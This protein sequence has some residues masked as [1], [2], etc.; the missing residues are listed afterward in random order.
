MVYREPADELARRAS[1]VEAPDHLTK[2]DVA[3][4]RGAD[5]VD[6]ADGDAGASP[7][8]DGA[9]GED[10]GPAEGGAP[11]GRIRVVLASDPGRETIATLHGD[12]RGAGANQRI[13]TEVD[14]VTA[15]EIVLVARGGRGGDGGTGGDGGPGARGRKGTDATRYSSGGNGGPGGDGGDGGNGTD[16]AR[17]GDGGEIVVRTTDEDTHLLML[18]A[19]DVRGGKGGKEGVNGAGGA[20]GSGGSGGSSYSWTE[21]ETYRDSNGDS[22]TRTTWH[23]NSGGSAGPDGRDGRYGNAVVADG[24]DG[25]DGSFAI[26]VL[27]KNATVGAGN[28]APVARYPSRYDLRL[29]RFVHTNDNDDGI[30]EP[31]EKVVLSRIAIENVGGMPTPAHHD[32]RIAIR[33][34]G[35]IAPSEKVLRL[36]RSLGAGETHVFDVGL[37]LTL[38]MF[39]PQ[40]SGAPLAAPETIHLFADL[41]D[42]R[43]AFGEFEKELPPDTGRLVVRFPVEVSPLRSLF[44]LG[45]G[46]AARMQWS[47]TNVSEKP[48]GAESMLGRAVAVH[49]VRSGGEL[50]SGDIHLFDP[51][52][53]RVSLEEGFRCEIPRLMPKE[54]ASFET[55]IAISE[56]APPYASARLV[57]AGE[58]GHIA[59]PK[60]IR[61]VQYQELTLRVGRPFDARDADVLF[62]VNNRTTG[63]ELASWEQLAKSNGLTSAVWD[64]ALEGG[65]SVLGDVARG[66]RG[67]RL[68]VMLNN[69]MDTPNGEK[70]ASTLAD[71]ATTL[72]VARAGTHILY[73][74]KSPDLVDLIVPSHAATQETKILSA[75]ASEDELIRACEA[76]IIGGDGATVDVRTW[77]AWPWSKVERAHLEARANALAAVLAKRWPDRRYVLVPRFAPVDEKKIGWIRIVH[78]GSLEVRRSTDP[79]RVALSGIEVHAS[80]MHD[81][82]FARESKTLGTMLHALPFT[83]KVALLDTSPNAFAG[84]GMLL[85]P[86]VAAVLGDLVRE[87]TLA[88]EASGWRASTDALRAMLPMLHAFERDAFGAPIELTTARGQRFVE[89]I[90]WLEHVARGHAR[91]WH[92][93]PP[94]MWLARGRVLRSFV[95]DAIERVLERVAEG[96][97]AAEA[98]R[99]AVKARLQEL[100]ASWESFRKSQLGVLHTRD[101]AESRVMA[102]FEKRPIDSDALCLAA[103]ERVLDP[104]QADALREKEEGRI[105]RSKA[106]VAGAAAARRELLHQA[107]CATFLA[108]AKS[109]VRVA[110]PPSASARAEAEVEAEAEAEATADDLAALRE[111]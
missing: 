100:E 73:V 93:A 45:P 80:A 81:E 97:A 82:A 68:V 74:G 107:T 15:G 29:R 103:D 87:Q 77:Y 34:D 43:R 110:E 21:T 91:W 76:E 42:V 72:A 47:I 18:L 11:G 39:R 71:K 28:D 65:L 108:N 94:I 102:P 101:H 35:W 85:D 95:R 96:E 44:S 6:G 64:A 33:D 67:Y 2:V 75:D 17:G 55:T 10:A 105:E 49:L 20:G 60:R 31:E 109:K 92:W 1:K 61:P 7:G 46:E 66:E 52:G 86:L 104:S 30:Y 9:R 16:G 51:T 38:R 19:H 54:S 99:A 27:D 36:P 58:L 12:T 57:V 90:A 69:M 22:Q 26:E 106:V 56:S 23:S 53:A 8:A 63:P 84:H 59:D 88:A 14:F 48:F 41:P 13:D 83:T 89:L 40:A 5:G 24:E 78:L 50:G 37:E 98:V 70:R 62:V 3:G 25:R 111:R 4:R 32:I 79:A